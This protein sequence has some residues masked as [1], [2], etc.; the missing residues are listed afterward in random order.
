V[1]A[2]GWPKPNNSATQVDATECCTARC[3]LLPWSASASSRVASWREDI[4]DE[5]PDN[6]HEAYTLAVGFSVATLLGSCGDTVERANVVDGLNAMVHR[7]GYALT[8]V[9]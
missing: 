3:S 9:T 1:T 4:T 7:T 8:P 5:F 2:A 6:P